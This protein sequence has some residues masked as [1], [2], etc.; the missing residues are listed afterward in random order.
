MAV[1]CPLT[2]AVTRPVEPK[3]GR[4]PTNVSVRLYPS[5][6]RA[7]PMI[8]VLP[9]SDVTKVHLAGKKTSTPGTSPGSK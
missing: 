7:R 8:V 2:V 3:Q 6:S 5:G 1:T 4:D 9:E